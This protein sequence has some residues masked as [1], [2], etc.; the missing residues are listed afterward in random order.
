MG[1]FG[2]MRTGVSGMNAQASKLGTVADNIANSSTTGYKRAESE[3]SSLVLSQGNGTYNSGGVEAKTRYAVS[4][5]GTLSFTTSSLDLAVDGNGFFIV[6]DA[7]GTPTLTRAGA[8]V[9]NGEGF[10]VNTA[11][12]RLQGYSLANGAQPNVVANGL[13]G[14]EDI[15]ISQNQ[16][17]AVPTDQALLW[18]NLPDDAVDVVPANL[19]SAN[20]A[21][22]EF[23]AK[24]S[25]IVYDNLGNEVKL[26]VYYTRTT[27]AGTNPVDWE[28]TVFDAA[29]A[30]PGGGFPYTGAALSTTNIQFDETT[31]NFNA[32]P[33]ASPTTINVAVPNGSTFDIDLSGSTYLAADFTVMEVN[34]NGNAPSAVEKVEFDTDGTLY[35]IYENGDRRGIYKIPLADVASPDKLRPST[36]NT[37]EVTT[38][39]GDVRVGFPGQGGL[40]DLQVGALEGSNVDL[41]SELTSMIESQRTYSANSKS[42]KA[43]SDLLQELVNLVR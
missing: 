41:A 43:G 9:P 15:N 4:D 17:D 23:S 18:T 30:A 39:S 42:F 2:V 11:G 36:G 8:F 32:G 38:D 20:A 10:L 35:A 31:G 33:P 29:N 1:L 34:T 7:A 16:L 22:A 40:G 19:P 21:T 12:Y 26:D 24:T 37:F 13:G 6:A 5:Q 3:F 14:L 28:V 27:P 25:L